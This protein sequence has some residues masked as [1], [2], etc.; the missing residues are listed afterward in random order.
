MTCGGNSYTGLNV[1]VTTDTDALTYT[2][3][4]GEVSVDEYDDYTYAPLC[5][6]GS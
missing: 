1:D 6:S 5:S 4:T 2:L 3:P